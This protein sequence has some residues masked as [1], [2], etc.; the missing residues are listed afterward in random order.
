MKYEV[1]EVF[2]AVFQ[3]CVLVKVNMETDSS[4]SFSTV[5]R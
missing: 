4:F 1:I 3:L 2:V 5:C